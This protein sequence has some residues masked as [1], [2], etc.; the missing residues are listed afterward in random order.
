[1][2]GDYGL[3]GKEFDFRGKA[4]LDAKV[5][6]MMT[7]WK[8]I[9]LKPVDPFFSKDGAGTEVPIQITGTQS[10]PHIGLDFHHKSE[11]AN[12]VRDTDSGSKPE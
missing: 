6:Q 11:H 3:D 7:G 2:T 9:L 5:S 4:R 1:M 12:V 8:S 10:E